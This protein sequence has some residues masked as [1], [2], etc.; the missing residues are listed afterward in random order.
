LVVVIAVIGV[1]IAMLLPAVQAAREAARR[2]SCSNNLMQLG[3]A[4][5][6]Y[7]SA[8]EELPSGVL[9]P[10]SPVQSVAVGQHHGWIVQILPYIEQRNAYEQVDFSSSVYGPKNAAVRAMR[11]ESLRCPSDPTNNPQASNYAACHHDVEAPIASDNHGVFFLN[12][13]VRF[14]DILDGSSNTIFL[15]E[16]LVEA[17]DLGWMSGTRATL[18]NSAIVGKTLPLARTQE[19]MASPTS[20]EAGSTGSEGQATAPAATPPGAAAPA[21]AGPGTAAPTAG[22]PNPT[23]PLY[24]GGF[25]AMHPGTFMV[26]LGDGSVRILTAFASPQVFQQ[27]CHRDDGKIMPEGL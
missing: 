18:R 15:G 17:G 5:Q 27:A 12:S 4:V 3:L 24:V 6:H 7:E 14:S 13:R 25:S 9:D 26:G 11:I 8:H 2:I 10:V 16:K 1:L 23:S 19:V 21:S 22:A 20:G